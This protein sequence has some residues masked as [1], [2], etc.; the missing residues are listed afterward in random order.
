MSDN[1]KMFLRYGLAVA[2]S[3][4]VGKGW[5]TPEQGNVVTDLVIQITGLVVSMFPAVYA[6]IN[7]D[8]S[9]KT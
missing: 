2:I 1:L 7:I 4:V 6:A 5:L 8:N 3:F 9:P